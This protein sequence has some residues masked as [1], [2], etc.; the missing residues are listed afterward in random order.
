MDDFRLGLAWPQKT[1]SETHSFPLTRPILTRGE[2]LTRNPFERKWEIRS[3]GNG[4]ASVWERIRHALSNVDGEQFLP[5]P[6]AMIILRSDEYLHRV[7]PD[8][9]A[10]GTLDRLPLQ[11]RGRRGNIASLIVKQ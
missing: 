5:S 1:P 6:G 7:A 10:G 3:V 2:V 9:R 4:T 11:G 8:H